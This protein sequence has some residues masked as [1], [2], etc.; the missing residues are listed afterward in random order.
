MADSPGKKI[1]LV[2]TD[3]AS[4]LGLTLFLQGHGYLTQTVAAYDQAMTAVQNWKPDLVILNI[5]IQAFNPLDFVSDLRRNPST[6]GQKI[7]IFSQTPDTG[8]VTG[9][10]PKVRGYLTKPVDFEALKALLNKTAP[11]A[12]GRQQTVVVA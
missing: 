11:P 6:E 5:L 2:D 1:L 4:A 8:I 10:S 7:I 3:E 12:A 9:P